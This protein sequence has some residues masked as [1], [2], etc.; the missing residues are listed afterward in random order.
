MFKI[1]VLH[2]V[3]RDAQHDNF[4]AVSA[5][6]GL[7][8]GLAWGKENSDIFFS[9]LNCIHKQPG[10]TWKVSVWLQSPLQGPGL[11]SLGSIATPNRRPLPPSFLFSLACPSTRILIMLPCNYLWVFSLSPHSPKSG[12]SWGL[13]LSP[14]PM[15]LLQT[16]SLLRPVK[17]ILQQLFQIWGLPALCS[18]T[19]VCAHGCL[20]IWSC[21]SP[22]SLYSSGWPQ[23]AARPQYISSTHQAVPPLADSL[24]QSGL[25]L[26]KKPFLMLPNPL[27]DWS[28]CPFTLP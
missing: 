21:L 14:G 28:T 22:H 25:T 1:C 17:S 7:P 8:S 15:Q 18:V 5:G 19:V 4:L 27:Q 9:P 3:L 2:R 26:S 23:A 10:F 24:H 20:W 12:L 6:L 11:P 16:S 13:I